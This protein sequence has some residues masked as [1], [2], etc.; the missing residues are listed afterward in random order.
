LVRY[1]LDIH[2]GYADHPQTVI[3]YF[4][5]FITM[6]GLGRGTDTPQRNAIMIKG[7]LAVGCVNEYF[8]SRLI[9]IEK[10]QDTSTFAY[11]WLEAGMP[12]T[13]LISECLHNMI[14]FVQ[15][16][17]TL[18]LLAKDSIP[19]PEGGGTLRPP[20]NVKN[21][22]TQ[23]DIVIPPGF[24][25]YDFFQKFKDAGSD[26][27]DSDLEKEAKQLDV[28]RE[29]FRLLAPNTAA[30]SNIKQSDFEPNPTDTFI[31]ARHLNQ[32]IMITATA[33]ASGGAGFGADDILKYYDYDTS[34]YRCEV[35]TPITGNFITE[36]TGKCPFSQG[37]SASIPLGNPEDK[38]EASEVDGET[39]IEGC[40]RKMT[41]VFGLPIYSPFGL[42][43][44]R[45][46]G[47][48]FS[49][50]V[51]MK[52]LDRFKNVEFKFQEIDPE[53]PLQPLAPFT[54]VPNNLFVKQPGEENGHPDPMQLS[55]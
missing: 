13:S 16:S 36:F 25:Q 26:P 37:G 14:A 5:D 7:F 34:K 24:N 32:F 39:V 53:E 33:V 4:D 52:L 30:F 8:E 46:A 43:Y 6:V 10:D 1:F 51:A 47:E 29:M 45:C 23:E 49:M 17:N 54:L 21:P 35:P 48:A 44:R 27:K 9:E 12:R 40:N 28:C 42:G 19:I 18:Y 41:P 20:I 2:V 50:F 38:F 22:F 31:Q 3:E 55:D 15:F 11:W